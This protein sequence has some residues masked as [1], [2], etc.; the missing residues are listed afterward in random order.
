MGTFLALRL[1]GVLQSW[2]TGAMEYKS[3]AMMPTKSGIIGMI[4]C[5]M[6][7]PRG[8][9]RLNQLMYEVKMAV[10]ADRAGT[11]M[12]DFQTVHSSQ[13]RNAQGKLKK[14]PGQTPGEYTIILTKEYLQDACFTV[15]LEAP[16]DTIL[17]MKEGLESPTWPIYLGRK[18]CVPSVPVCMGTFEEASLHKAICHVALCSRADESIPIEWDADDAQKTRQDVYGKNHWYSRMIRRTYM[19]AED[20]QASFQ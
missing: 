13:F 14:S 6:G 15:V 17:A 4:G 20:I 19:T 7:I 5:A 2:G 8:D 1:E 18:G 10:R 12:T 11:V 16:L 3:T 9:T